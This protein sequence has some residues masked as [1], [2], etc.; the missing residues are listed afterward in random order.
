MYT[1]N[2]FVICSTFIA[3]MANTSAQ[4]TTCAT[5]SPVLAGL[6]MVLYQQGGGGFIDSPCHTTPSF[7][8]D[9]Q[10]FTYTAP[11]TCAVTISSCGGA[12]DM[13][14][15][16]TVFMGTCGNLQCIAAAN[17]NCLAQG[18]IFDNTA[19]TVTVNVIAG[20]SYYI[21][22]DETDG[23]DNYQWSI[24]ECL[25][26][27]QGTSYVDQNG[28]GSH[29]ASEPLHPMCISVEPDGEWFY[30]TGDPYINCL[31]L[32]SYTITAPAAPP[33]H[34]LVPASHSFNITLPGDAVTGK[35]FAL[36]PTPGIF[37]VAVDLWGPDGWIGNNSPMHITCSNI[38]TMPIT[39]TIILSLDPMANFVEADPSPTTSSAQGATWSLPV[40]Q[41]GEVLQVDVTIFTSITAVP[42]GPM[43]HTVMVSTDEPDVNSSNNSDN[44]H[45]FAATSIDPNDKHVSATSITPDDVADQLPLE[46]EIRFQNT[47][48]APAV[49]IVVQ[50]S[51]DADWDL[52][53]FQMIGATHPYTL[54]MSGDV[55][56][57]TFANI[58][59][60][61]STT[62]EPESHGSIHYR[63]TPKT[64]L[65]LGGQ[66]TNRADIYFDYNE[67]VLTNTTVTTVELESGV[68][69]EIA[70]TE[71]SVVPSP[72][73]G[74]I[75]I[76]W[77]GAK[78]KTTL[79]VVDALGREVHREI[80]STLDHQQ[81]VDLSALPPGSY[82]AHASNGRIVAHARF[83]I[84]N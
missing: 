80:M 22:W 83:V 13:Q 12:L 58:M 5:A 78:D 4:N 48:T 76:R 17:D 68:R 11:A 40:M 21:E 51:V 64:S 34:T 70:T 3:S 15:R 31:D 50:D 36:V 43:V 26:S 9:A 79:I 19:C 61:D 62:N 65:G 44:M 25:N 29:D 27:V 47:G 6:H 20:F 1:R 54:W 35:D 81:P 56:V 7:G 38:G 46:Y 30:S 59:L 75:Y 37:D 42:N 39:P 63:I 16:L 24:T 28:N 2:A 57:W 72:S 14:S 67:A 45:R 60:A 82:C 77:A 84:Q 10:W 23:T 49:N 52:G 71:M 18:P 41:P 32:G 55:L 33:Y 53:T 73:S 66:L 8:N 74:L 69:E